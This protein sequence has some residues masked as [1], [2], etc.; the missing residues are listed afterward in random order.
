VQRQRVIQ[1]VQDAHATPGM[2]IGQF[3]QQLI[4]INNGNAA[5]TC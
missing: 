3:S 4:I 1:Y 2:V 5:Q